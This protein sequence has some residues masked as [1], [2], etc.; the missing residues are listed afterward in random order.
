MGS[1]PGSS[2][3]RSAVLHGVVYIAENGLS[4]RQAVAAPRAHMEEGLLKVEIAERD[5]REVDLLRRTF[6]DMVEFDEPGMYFGGLHVAG[7]G[8]EGFAGAGDPRRSGAFGV[9]Q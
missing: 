1:S 8:L 2:R 9:Y 7:L 6:P 5:P 4:P 3:I